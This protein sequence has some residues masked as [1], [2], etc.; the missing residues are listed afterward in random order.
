MT[1]DLVHQL[2]KALE[3]AERACNRTRGIEAFYQDWWTLK[4]NVDQLRAMLDK[5]EEAER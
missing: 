1:S 3:A 4:S 2:R 5:Y